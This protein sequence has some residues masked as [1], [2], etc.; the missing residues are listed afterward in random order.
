MNTGFFADIVQE[1]TI[2]WV[3]CGQDHSTDAWG[4]YGGVGLSFG[5]KSGF[6]SFG[7]KFSKKGARI[8]DLSFDLESGAMDVETWIREDDGLIDKQE[9]WV[10]PQTF[11]WLKTPYCHASEKLTEAQKKRFYGKGSVFANEK[12]Q[13]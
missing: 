11:S 1:G 2:Q 4:T 3:A 7:P 5:R 12:H 10:P 13:N 6:G 8:F 9:E